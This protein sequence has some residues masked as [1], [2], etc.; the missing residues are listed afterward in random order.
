MARQ[1][2]G[3]TSRVSGT[4]ARASCASTSVGGIIGRVGRISAS[5]SV[6]SASICA[7]RSRARSRPRRWHRG[8]ALPRLQPCAHIL[9]HGRMIGQGAQAA[10]F[11]APMM[12][13]LA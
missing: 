5:A 7:I 4:T 9:A 13:R 3:R 11:S 12:T 8:H 10:Q 1:V 2:E 6:S